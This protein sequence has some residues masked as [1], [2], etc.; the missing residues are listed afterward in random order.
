MPFFPGS[1]PFMNKF[2]DKRTQFTPSSPPPTGESV[3]GAAGAAA[4]AAA[5]G[6]EG[7]TQAAAAAA[8]SGSKPPT[9][10]ESAGGPGPGTPPPS[11][12]PQATEA[13]PKGPQT[14]PGPE[15][16]VPGTSQSQN[17]FVAKGET[18]DDVVGEST[19]ARPGTRAFQPFAG[20]VFAQSLR[21]PSEQAS[22]NLSRDFSA[23]GERGDLSRAFSGG[24]GT[25]SGNLGDTLGDPDDPMSRRILAQMGIG[26]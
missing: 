23:A 17:P 3:M 18:V 6:I 1:N 25:G 2:V 19:F 4:A 15:A 11:P 26:G 21:S 13:K 24:A 7:A 14:V 12:P 16:E 9:Q 8:G 22:Q 5:Q 10:Q 20:R